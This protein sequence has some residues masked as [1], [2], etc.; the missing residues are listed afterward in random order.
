M[1]RGRWRFR[2]R[3][4]DDVRCSFLMR[5]RARP[6]VDGS[7]WRACGMWLR[8]R[9]RVEGPRGPHG[10]GA[11]VVRVIWPLCRMHVIGSLRMK[12]TPGAKNSSGNGPRSASAP[13]LSLDLSCCVSPACVSRASN[14]NL[15]SLKR[16]SIHPRGA[17]AAESSSRGR[18]HL[19]MQASLASLSRSLSRCAGGPGL[20][21]ASAF[22]VESASPPGLWFPTTGC[23]LSRA[24]SG[25]TAGARFPPTRRPAQSTTRWDLLAHA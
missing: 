8:S 6:S 15:S 10:S 24:S 13:S 19:V 12:I 14:C 2:R 7:A 3:A 18:R 9:R 23:P 21:C 17:V 22:V 1:A 25:L 5:W 4:S 20:G 16:V 11:C